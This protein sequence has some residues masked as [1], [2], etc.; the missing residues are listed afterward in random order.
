MG[1]PRA[2][3]TPHGFRGG[4]LRESK[5]AGSIGFDNKNARYKIN[6][7]ILTQAFQNANGKTHLLIKNM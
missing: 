6:M 7:L 3:H 1:A 5:F 2:V 4:L